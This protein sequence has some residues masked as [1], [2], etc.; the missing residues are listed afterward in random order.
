MPPPPQKIFEFISFEIVSGAVLGRIFEDVILCIRFTL[1]EGPA[2]V[3]CTYY[4]KP[5]Y[6]RRICSSWSRPQTLQL[7]SFGFR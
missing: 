5:T 7:V 6:A 3:L 1:A 4:G 2:T